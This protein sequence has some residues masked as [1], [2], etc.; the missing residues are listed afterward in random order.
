M[1]KETLKLGITNTIKVDIDEIINNFKT[2]LY[3][4]NKLNPKEKQALLDELPDKKGNSKKS[5]IKSSGGLD[6]LLDAFIRF[7]YKIFGFYVEKFLMLISDVFVTLINNY[8]LNVDFLKGKIPNGEGNPTPM[9]NL[10]YSSV[11]SSNPATLTLGIATQLASILNTIKKIRN[12]FKN[13]IQPVIQ[14]L[15][16]TR[17]FI[18]EKLLGDVFKNLTIPFP[19]L[20][21]G[22]LGIQLPGLDQNNL[23]ETIFKLPELNIDIKKFKDLKSIITELNKLYPDLKLKSTELNIEPNIDLSDVE[24]YQK[25]QRD[26]I[27]QRFYVNKIN[28]FNRTPEFY[29]ENFRNS[30]NR[31]DLESL[32]KPDVNGIYT[33]TFDFLKN[34]KL[35]DE[36]IVIN[37]K[38][39]NIKGLLSFFEE[40]NLIYDKNFIQTFF[41]YLKSLAPS[42]YIK[43]DEI[44]S[45]QNIPNNL[46]E[47][48]NN[49]DFNT[50]KLVFDSSN[51]ISNSSVID[52]DVRTLNNV[53][54]G[55][56]PRKNELEQE[57]LYENSLEQYSI[58][59]KIKNNTIIG[60][61]T[62]G[63]YLIVNNSVVAKG[64][65]IEILIK[66]YLYYLNLNNI[67]DDII[68]GNDEIGYFFIQKKSVYLSANTYIELMENY[69]SLEDN[70]VYIS[71]SEKLGV[72]YLYKDGQIISSGKTINE[73]KT[74]ENIFDLLLFDYNFNTDK[75][76][77]IEVL[78]KTYEYN[79]W[80][81]ETFNGKPILYKNGENIN[82][83][84][85]FEKV[86][87]LITSYNYKL[88]K[89]NFWNLIPDDKLKYFNSYNK[90]EYKKYI[91]N[92]EEV[93]EE[94]DEYIDGLT[95]NV[96]DIIR[97]SNDRINEKE[98][99]GI[100]SD[101]KFR[102]AVNLPN[103]ENKKMFGDNYDLISGLPNFKALSLMGLIPLLKT[104]DA[105]ISYLI[106][107]M[108]F[109]M[110]LLMF[111]INML[112]GYIEKMFNIVKKLITLNIPGALKD[113]ADLLLSLVP[114]ISLFKKIIK[115]LM[116]PIIIPYI[117]N[118]KE[119]F[120]KF[121]NNKVDDN[122]E[123][124][125]SKMLDPNNGS[126][127][128]EK[129]I[130][131]FKVNF[132]YY[133]NKSNFDGSDDNF[134][135]FNQLDDI[136]DDIFNEPIFDGLKSFLK[137]IPK[138]LKAIV[139]FFVDLMIPIGI[140]VLDD[141]GIKTYILKPV[142]DVSISTIEGNLKIKLNKLR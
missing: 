69:I 131:D 123:D 53:Y 21:F 34:F 91:L 36:K 87:Y 70:G 40:S 68:I 49:Y 72:V 11:L 6:S 38:E 27:F 136:L 61:S 101:N 39:E 54:S 78:K 73:L 37:G 16:K 18:I 92:F 109:L 133:P 62:I 142:T 119:Q 1:A 19:N 135:E 33:Y 105:R 84:L 81:T 64:L 66:N 52:V 8:L 128:F 108:E 74:Y 97:L 90:Y 125:F 82:E 14:F 20:P 57:D 28:E 100:I 110:N 13:I 85:S 41:N 138:I 10:I 32:S 67:G 106:T 103:S 116:L 29:K 23:F 121:S 26:P 122:I 9:S 30:D 63:Y 65:N 45:Y 80:N 137:W 140:K 93:E 46:R 98:I 104:K 139:L 96:F 55:R 24:F 22:F 58:D 117:K 25:L 48:I 89:L 99:I 17:T 127:Y 120:K 79:F 56:N 77:L 88:F 2:T 5:K 50:K 42:G 114:T 94:V 132:D 126:G 134:D 3:D 95:T 141:V 83:K 71:G 47:K 130:L 15:T 31:K 44:L 7:F 43:K 86:E 118:L 59:N 76:N 111:P 107:I 51:S 112:L 124:L 75:N 113:V 4:L 129:Y 115:G 60:N 12:L 35:N 102:T